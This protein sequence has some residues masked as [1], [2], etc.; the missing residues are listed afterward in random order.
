MP[1]DLGQH[2]RVLRNGAVSNR[3]G[4]PMRKIRRVGCVALVLAVVATL[5]AGPSAPTA[6]AGEA[7]PLFRP[8]IFVHGFAGS[9]NQFESQAMRFA[10]NG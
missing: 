8:L 1:A 3:P 9:G 10:S 5:L 2:G 7:E 4:G 6:G